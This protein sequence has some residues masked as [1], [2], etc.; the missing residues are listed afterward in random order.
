MYDVYESVNNEW[1]LNS[2]IYTSS[3]TNAT[4]KIQ[5]ASSIRPAEIRSDPAIA[6]KLLSCAVNNVVKAAILIT[7]CQVVK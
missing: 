4:N 6:L 2:N 5:M 7:P 1:A 3:I